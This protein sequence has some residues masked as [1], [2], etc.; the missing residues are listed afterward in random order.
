MNLIEVVGKLEADK[1]IVMDFYDSLIITVHRL[2]EMVPS[3]G[4]TTVTETASKSGQK[5]KKGKRKSNMSA[6]ARAKQSA[7]MKKYWADKRKGK[8]TKKTA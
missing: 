6:A 2:S 4:G 8:K 1:Q 3:S 5:K 7:R